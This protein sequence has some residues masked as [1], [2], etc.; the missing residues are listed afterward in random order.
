MAQSFRVPNTSEILTN[1]HNFL[2]VV[3]NPSTT[4]LEQVAEYRNQ[5]TFFSVPNMPATRR[6][7]ARSPSRS[8]SR[9][10]GAEASLTPVSSK[11]STPDNADKADKADKAGKKGPRSAMSGKAVAKDESKRQKIYTRV[12]YGALMVI[13]F[14]MV[15]YAGHIYLCGLVALIEVGLF[16]EL[17]K[18]RYSAHLSTIEE[19]VRMC[20]Q[21]LAQQYLQCIS[22]V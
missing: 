10:G 8:R 13:G 15:M 3:S 19:Q 20:P 18:V 14:L 22:N 12:F 16:N 5:Y 1:F 6:S 21:I 11:A 9:S 2:Y 4:T 7:S 17:V